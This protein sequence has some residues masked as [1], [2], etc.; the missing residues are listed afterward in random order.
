MSKW[1]LRE[2]IA[3]EAARLM[4]RGKEREYAAARKRAARWLSRRRL[5][6]G[7]LPSNAEIDRQLHTLAG[8][9]SDEQQ[10]GALAA[11]R[12]TALDVMRWLAAFEPRLTGPAVEGPVLTGAE[13][14]LLVTGE[15]DAVAAALEAAGVH[16]RRTDSFVPSIEHSRAECEPASEGEARHG[17]PR[18][19]GEPASSPV[20]LEFFHRFP[21]VV[22]VR[23]AAAEDET[24]AALDAGELEQLVR[25]TPRQAD[26]TPETAGD[27]G[28]DDDAYDPDLFPLLR[29]LLERLGGIRLDPV[30]H[31]EGDALYHSLQVYALG[32]EARPWDEEFLLACLLHDVGLGIDRRDPDRAAVEALSGVLTERTC[33]LIARRREARDYLKTGRVSRSLRRSE[34]FDDLLLLAQCDQQ[35]RIPG[36]PVPTVDEALDYIAGLEQAWDE[37]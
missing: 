34:H 8:L 3:A 33:L 2:A 6:A 11:M 24:A 1:K 30:R 23:D 22:W 32:L 16:P 20:R 17:V 25:Q 13:V 7:D 12:E 19:Q 10:T 27:G 28:A 36:A 37:A 26:E 18:L 21:C 5:R 9:F 31:P 15:P 35:G 4:L 14:V 29:I